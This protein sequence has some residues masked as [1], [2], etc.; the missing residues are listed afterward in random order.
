MERRQHQLA[1]AEVLGAV[2]HEHRAA[3]EDRGEQPVRF[4]CVEPL[5]R[6]VKHLPDKGRVEQHHEAFVERGPHVDR[7]AV[8]PA[9]ELEKTGAAKQKAKRQNPTWQLRPRREP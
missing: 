7:A 2:E 6:P 5:V 9:A 1:V 8:A 4:T 3:A